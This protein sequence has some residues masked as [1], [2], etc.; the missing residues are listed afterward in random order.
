MKIL[1]REQVIHDLEDMRKQ[2]HS[3]AHS[4]VK[5]LAHNEMDD[6]DIQLL[7]LG[8]KEIQEIAKSILISIEI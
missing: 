1:N 8:V 3:L 6:D 2:A 7:A 4:F 5:P